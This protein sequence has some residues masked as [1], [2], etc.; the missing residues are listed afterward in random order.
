MILPSDPFIG[1]DADAKAP[2]PAPEPTPDVRMVALISHCEHQA[3]HGAPVSSYILNELRALKAW[4][5]NQ[6]TS[7]TY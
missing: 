6:G 4:Y 3:K 7:S 2:A 5:D 1:R